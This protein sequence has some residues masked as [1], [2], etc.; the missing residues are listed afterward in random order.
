M[1][2]ARYSFFG[3]W[4]RPSGLVLDVYKKGLADSEAS[5]EAV[6]AAIPEG[7]SA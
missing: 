6:P 2:W 4:D 1:V 7:P 5:A 3:Y